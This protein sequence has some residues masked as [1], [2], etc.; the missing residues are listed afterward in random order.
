MPY[1]KKYVAEVG[2]AELTGWAKALWFCV[3]VGEECMRGH[4]RMDCSFANFLSRG[5]N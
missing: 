3:H 4:G 2:A 5:I 1:F